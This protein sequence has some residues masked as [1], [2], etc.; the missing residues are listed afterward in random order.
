MEARPAFYKNKYLR[1]QKPRSEKKRVQ[2][3]NNATR[4]K[5]S[6]DYFEGDERREADNMEHAKMD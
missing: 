5:L 3:K 2:S 6:V 4:K 1:S